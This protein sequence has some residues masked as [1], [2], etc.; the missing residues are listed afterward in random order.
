ME[1]NTKNLQRRHN[2]PVQFF[3]GEKY[4]IYKNE[5]YFSRGTKRLHRVVYEY[6]KGK[7]P[8]GMHVHHI[9][10]NPQNNNINNLTLVDANKHVRVHGKKRAIN[11][12]QW[13]KKFYTAGIEKAKEWHA[14]EDGHK[15]HKQHAKKFDFG[16]ITYGKK[17]CEVCG[18]EFIAKKSDQKFCS[19]A[20]KSKYRRIIGADNITKICPICGGEFT[21]SKYGKHTYCSKK[22]SAKSR[23]K[24]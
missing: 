15:W 5:R 18:S 2:L 1:T 8:D 12:K 19:N 20:C 7:I 6:F 13:L 9:D 22:C 4:T 3:N 11:N 21:C 24:E 10:G 23:S 17:N 14:S 16:H